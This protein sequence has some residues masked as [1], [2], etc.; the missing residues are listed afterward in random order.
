MNYNEVLTEVT[1]LCS[2]AIVS[3]DDAVKRIAIGDIEHALARAIRGETAATE[4]EIHEA[5]TEEP[6]TVGCPSLVPPRIIPHDEPAAEVPRTEAEK[7]GT[8]SCFS[9]GNGAFPIRRANTEEGT[10]EHVWIDGR[11]FTA[12]T[13][14]TD[15]VDG[16]T[17]QCEF[18]IRDNGQIKI[19]A[20]YYGGKSNANKIAHKALK[21]YIKQLTGASKFHSR[22]GFLKQALKRLAERGGQET[23]ATKKEPYCT[24]SVDEEIQA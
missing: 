19:V 16:V 11:R 9:L 21:T 18:T 13:V 10:M 3:N 20:R 5:A 7:Q 2:Q 1:H 22:G 8:C 24:I 23:S 12:E 17:K 4:D 14:I 15:K 6:V